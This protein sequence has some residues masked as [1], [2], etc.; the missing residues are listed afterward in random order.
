MVQG[1]P[2]LSLTRKR[3]PYPMSSLIRQGRVSYAQTKAMVGNSYH[4]KVMF[5][6]VFWILCTTRK[7]ALISQSDASSVF[8][9]MP[10]GRHA[11]EIDS[12]TECEPTQQ[13]PVTPEES[14]TQPAA[15]VKKARLQ[16]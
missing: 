8:R 12:D 9:G 13:A 1:F 16:K 4:A 3:A 15:L 11:I 14:E 2:S 5:S 7:R 10:S 6:I